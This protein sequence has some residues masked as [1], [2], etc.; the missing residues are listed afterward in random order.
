[1]ATLSINVSGQKIVPVP[2]SANLTNLTLTDALDGQVVT[3]EFQQN[4]TGGFTVASTSI[5][6]LRQ[7]ASGANAVSQQNVQ[8]TALTNSWNAVPAPASAVAQALVASGA[9]ALLGGVTTL[10]SSGAIAITL[11]QPV[12]GEQDGLEMTF[13]AVTEHAHTITTSADG[14][15]GIGDTLTFA[16]AH[17]GESV[18]LRA[19]GGVWFMVNA[20]GVVLTEV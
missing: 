5:N 1:M 15:D 13:I 18:T 20:N 4:S 6:G 2:L 12:A 8:Y 9:A 3:L 14:I 16:A 19:I 7:P 17:L 11:A 10:G